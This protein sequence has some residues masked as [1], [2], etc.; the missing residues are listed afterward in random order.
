MDSGLLLSVFTSWEVIAVCL[1][2]MLFLPLVFFVASTKS[3]P[4]K[5]SAA[6]ARK[7]RSAAQP[8]A[9]G[10]AEASAERPAGPEEETPARKAGAERAARPGATE[11]PEDRA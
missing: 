3:R 1:C 5:P 7:G 9:T 8:S 6:A 11:P 10:A 2:V 4:A